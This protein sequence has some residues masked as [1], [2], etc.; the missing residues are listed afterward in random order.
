LQ[1]VNAS[2]RLT[3]SGFFIQEN[4]VTDIVIAVGAEKLTVPQFA[5]MNNG[6]LTIVDWNSF[7]KKEQGFLPAPF[8]FPGSSNPGLSC[9]RLVIRIG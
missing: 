7:K 3:A 6:C 8:I 2:A 9:Y 4:L 1:A 5:M